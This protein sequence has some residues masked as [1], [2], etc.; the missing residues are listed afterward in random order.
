MNK[1]LF[2]LLLSLPSICLAA[3]E[4]LDALFGSDSEN[5]SS[6]AASS[7]HLAAPKPQRFRH[8]RNRS[9][10]TPILP[11]PQHSPNRDNQPSPF[12]TYVKEFHLTPASTQD[13]D[14]RRIIEVRNALRT[15]AAQDPYDY[16][17]LKK[18]LPDEADL[19]DDLTK[20]HGIRDES[21]SAIVQAFELLMS[22]NNEQ[23][24][25]I[26][27]M[28]KE[29]AAQ[30]AQ[31]AETQ[32]V[33]EELCRHI[34][35]STTETTYLRTVMESIQKNLEYVTQLDMNTHSTVLNIERNAQKQTLT[36][37]S[38]PAM[39]ATSSPQGEKRKSGG[40]LRRVI[41]PPSLP[42]FSRENS[43]DK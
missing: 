8:Q 30:Q 18:H 43:K 33:T 3:D 21:L 26:S 29:M 12:A 27:Q 10:S 37:A 17:V 24:F 20:L 14:R 19:I 22:K 35:T 40:L 7:S 31:L 2:A 32:R 38:A 28:A 42:R 1:H 15:A 5:D 4:N 16:T 25:A 13:P 6:S 11:S 9:L 23:L 41:S 34:A 39:A 36:S